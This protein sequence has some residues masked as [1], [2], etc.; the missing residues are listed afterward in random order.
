[1]GEE[2][3]V[4][5]VPCRVGTIPNLVHALLDTAAEWPVLNSSLAA[6]LGYDSQSEGQPMTLLTRYG[7]KEGV[8]VSI[9]VHFS[10]EQG[11]GLDVEVRWFVCDDWYGPPVIGWKGC[12]QWLR[13]AL[14]PDEDAFYFT[15][16]EGRNPD[17][18]VR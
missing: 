5:A 2:R 1:V 10:A 7:R 17:G 12:L 4:I 16:A 3:L 9:P 15:R 11:E 13:F 14:N 6:A 8:I 18:P